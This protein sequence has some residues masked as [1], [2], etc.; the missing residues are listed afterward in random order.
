MPNDN[1]SIAVKPRSIISALRVSGLFC[2]LQLFINIIIAATGRS[3]V[4]LYNFEDG[5][6]IHVFGFWENVRL[7]IWSELLLFVPILISLLFIFSIIRSPRV[8]RIIEKSLFVTSIIIV[9]LLQ[10]AKWLKVI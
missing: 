9:A 4:T 8:T 3:A 7:S 5:N 10:I 2:G 6:P 1:L